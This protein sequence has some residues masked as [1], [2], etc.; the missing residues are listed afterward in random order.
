MS[1]IE[2]LEKA[3]RELQKTQSL[4]SSPHLTETPRRIWNY[5]LEYTRGAKEKL[6]IKTFP[7][8]DY[9]EIIVV[10]DIPFTSVC[11]HHFLPFSGEVSVAYLPDKK[12]IGLSKIPRIVHH[13]TLMPQYQEKLTNEIADYL[14][15]VLE[16]KGVMVK[17]SAVHSCMVARGAKTFGKMVTSALRGEFLRPEVKQ[18]A[19]ELMR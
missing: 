15:K 6:K 7:N 10:R 17:M 19:L 2:Y 9:D 11:I 1:G 8:E 18:E 4:P 13:F 16:P 5:W 3:I 12:L 14:Y